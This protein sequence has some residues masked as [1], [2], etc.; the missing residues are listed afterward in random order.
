MCGSIL[1][2]PPFFHSFVSLVLFYSLQPLLSI[3]VVKFS[4]SYGQSLFLC[5]NFLRDS[6]IFLGTIEIAFQ[7]QLIPVDIFIWISLIVILQN[8]N[9][10]SKNMYIF[11]PYVISLNR[12]F[13][14]FL[15]DSA[16]FLL[17][18]LLGIL[19]FQCFYTQSHLVFII[20]SV[21]IVY[22]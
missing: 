2:V 20:I 7:V 15:L 6:F 4:I 8:W 14:S 16:N 21:I 11:S 3:T 5:Q 18:L 12:V 13:S 17:R 1:K 10:L 22:V 9:F 19:Y